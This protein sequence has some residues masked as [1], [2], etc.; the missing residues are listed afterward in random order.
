MISSPFASL[1]LLVKKKDGS[2]PFCVDYRA[3]NSITV[4]NKHPLPV[5]EEFVKKGVSVCVVQ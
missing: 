2:W 1:V 5:V 4:K 3:L